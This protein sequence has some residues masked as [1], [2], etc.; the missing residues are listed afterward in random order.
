MVHDAGILFFCVFVSLA[1]SIFNSTLFVIFSLD[2]KTN[3][4]QAVNLFRS[5]SRFIAIVFLFE[6]GFDNL[7]FIGIATLI[8]SL[9]SLGLSFILTRL[10][11]VEL[12][13][14]IRGFNRSVACCLLCFGGWF[15]VNQV[16][17]VMFSKTDILLINEYLGSS[18]S[19]SYAVAQKI[20]DF[21]R[22][23]SGVIITL[24][25]PY[26]I[27]YFGRST[28]KDGKYLSDFMSV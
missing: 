6:L 24:V 18:S 28:S 25:S 17:L 22:V 1:V 4:I 15:L 11:D 7:A 8:S 21:F 10:V 9:L 23:Y 26:L 13:F 5:F 16:G 20:G 27:Y 14:L 2:N 12:K 19:G 3:Y